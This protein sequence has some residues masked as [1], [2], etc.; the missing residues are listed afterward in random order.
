MEQEAHVDISQYTFDEFVSFLFDHEVPEGPPHKR[1]LWYSGTEITHIPSLTCKH[2][3]RLFL[4]PRVLLERF[5]K[6]QLKQGFWAIPSW[7]L[8]CSV[9]H[10]LGDTDLP[11]AEKEQCM[12]SM[13]DLFKYFFA[14]EPL[15]SSGYMWWDALCYDWH[16]GVRKRDNG[17]E[18][19]Q[20]Q[21]VIFETLSEILALDSEFCQ[22]AALHGM[23]H[24]H[25]PETEKRV[26][27]HLSEHPS[28]GAG[29]K[30]YA[31]AAARFELQ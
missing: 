20:L 26:N 1:N 2:Y 11:F 27:R 18:D 5:S 30:E 4:Q 24:L 19:L 8:E 13:V 6:A 12:R 23:N 29:Q 22:R 3:I 31:L 15:D 10:L 7:N 16:C 9:N 25:H 14:A 28:L 17:G 21:E